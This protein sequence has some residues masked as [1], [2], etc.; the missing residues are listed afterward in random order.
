MPEVEVPHVSDLPDLPIETVCK[1]CIV[2]GRVQRVSY[3]AYARTEALRLGLTGYARN[4]P[5]GR[6]EVLACGGVQ[7][8][9]ALIRWLWLGSPRARV[10]E[11]TARA[12]DAADSPAGFGAS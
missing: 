11:V 12:A 3:R 6:V 1:R 4:L 5:D 9:D 7:A 10:T 8:V 2:S